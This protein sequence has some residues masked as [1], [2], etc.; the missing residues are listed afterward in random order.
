VSTGS[1]RVLH[2]IWWNQIGGI[3]FNLVDLIEHID[4]E[5]YKISLCIL[6][7]GELN[8]SG[9]LTRPVDIT[10]FGFSSGAD[11]VGLWRFLRYLRTQE[12]AIVHNHTRTFLVSAAIMLGR[13][14]I[15]RIFQE[16]GA[17]LQSMA[18]RMRTF[19]RCFGSVY[20]G[21]IAVAHSLVPQMTAAGLPEKKIAVIENPID[22]DKFNGESPRGE[23]KQRLALP[24]NSLAVGTACRLVQEKDIDLFLLVARHLH[25]ARK[26]IHFI[27]AGTGPLEVPLQKAAHACGLD[28]AV[29][30]I[31]ARTDMPMIYR[32]IDIFLFT[33][34]VESFGRTLLEA[35]ACCTPVVA[36][37]PLSGGAIELI[38]CSPGVVSIPNRRPEDLA[39]CILGLLKSKVERE[40]I[41]TMG[42]DWVVARFDV[43]DWVK[44][45]QCLYDD[46]VRLH[47]HE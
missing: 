16:H 21:F 19:Y 1:L 42:R 23:A 10:E 30:F 5:R 11:L 9:V 28:G 27:V 6:A 20:D 32:A 25:T 37:L 31:G 12:F 15:G 33:S 24:V 44:K 34:L 41:G 39:R 18:G 47:K 45:V 36:A 8:L 46:V 26:D 29:H 3:A 7:K 35:Q 22:A 13:K 2:I 17:L 4:Q 38:Q 40:R 43:R 14:R